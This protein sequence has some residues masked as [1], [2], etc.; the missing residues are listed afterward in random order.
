MLTENLTYK[1]VIWILF[2]DFS[3]EHTITSLAKFAKISRVGAWKILK[4]LEHEGLIE[5]NPLGDGKTS[6]YMVHLRWENPILAKILVLFLA[7]EASKY[8]RWA[9]DF[10]DLED[11]VEFMV[12][13]GSV[14][15]SFK[16]AN[17]IDIL[18]V[19]KEKDI[20]KLEDI[21]FNIQKTQNR[22]IHSIS[23]TKKELKQELKEKNRAL[24]D[25]V[26]KGIVLFGQE[27]FVNF[28]KEVHRHEFGN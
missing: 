7:Q 1:K 5:L 18:C 27:N 11:K 4:K 25:A 26:K 28:M 3:T 24:I 14:L 9:F 6:A 13:F 22:K 19:A 2:K 23:F 12:L 21:V 16:D 15:F 17:D 20:G 8:K 10:S